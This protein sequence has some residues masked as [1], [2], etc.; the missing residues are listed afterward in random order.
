MTDFRALVAGMDGVVLDRLGDVAYVG[1]RELR[2]MFYAPW[3]APALGGSRSSI[4]EPHFSVRDADA[5]AA[6]KKGVLMVPQ[7]G[8]FDIVN[9]HPDGSGWTALI[10]RQRGPVGA[11]DGSVYDLK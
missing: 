7:Q 4:R 2:G 10:L 6:P 1:A 8:E 11:E 5:A 3:L 9:H